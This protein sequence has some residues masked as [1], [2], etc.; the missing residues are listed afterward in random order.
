MFFS[1]HFAFCFDI[2]QVGVY[3][4]GVAYD[5][6]Y[7]DDVAYVSG[8]DGVEVIDVSDRSNPIRLTSIGNTGGVFGLFI[9]G[10][11][12]YVAAESNG[13]MMYDVSNPSNPRL[14]GSSP[15]VFSLNVYVQGGLAFVSSGSSFS[16]VNVSDPEN[17][18]IV[19]TVLGDE[20]SYRTHV[21]GDTLYLGEV[22]EGLIVYDISDPSSPVYLRTLPGTAGIFDIEVSE[23]TLFL[24]CHGAG[25][26]VLDIAVRD[27]PEIIGSF[28]N[29]G[30]AYGL[31]V[32][33][34]ILLAADLQQGVEV[35]D[36]SNP[37]SPTLLASFTG[38]HPHEIAGDQ[39]FIYLADQ[40][41]GLEV[42]QYGED[43]ERSQAQ[44]VEQT[45]ENGIPIPG[46]A[47][48]LGVCIYIAFSYDN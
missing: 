30:E 7:S 14:L 26:K 38:T 20:R 23:N 4:F 42:F 5:I 32:V 25:V 8:N 24:A 9:V 41:D 16:I 37:R 36:V 33:G 19:S 29:G 15:C 47:A 27:S 13:L 39:F 48:I 44:V 40:D 45:Q 28:N 12:L 21:V 34:D 35:L 6:V 22:N 3:D 10:D 31:Y 17:T 2:N 11:T 46:L 1:T 18:V 43:V